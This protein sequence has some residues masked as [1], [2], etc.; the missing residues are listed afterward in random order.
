MTRRIVAVAASLGLLAGCAS[1]T[2]V[3]RNA[4]GMTAQCGPYYGS[5]SSTSALVDQIALRDCVADF[6]RQGYE[7]VATP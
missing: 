2:V 5:G 1:E 7:R 6:Q 3:L 4:T